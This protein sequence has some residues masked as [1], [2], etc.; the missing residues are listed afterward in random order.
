MAFVY[1]LGIIAK[2]GIGTGIR[3]EIAELGILK[4]RILELETLEPKI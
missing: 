2:T 1:I 4:L 3:P